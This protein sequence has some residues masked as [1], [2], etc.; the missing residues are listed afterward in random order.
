MGWFELGSLTALPWRL[1]S[2]EREGGQV[3]DIKRGETTG[4]GHGEAKGGRISF[5]ANA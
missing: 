3:V 4:A 2:V 5:A 1:R